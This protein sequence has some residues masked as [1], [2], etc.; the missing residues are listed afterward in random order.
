MDLKTWS[1]FFYLVKD[2]LLIGS[3][4]KNFSERVLHFF[5]VE[6]PR[7]ES[8]R[9][10][11]RCQLHRFVVDNANAVFVVVDVRR[12][13]AAKNRD[14]LGIVGPEITPSQNGTKVKTTCC[15]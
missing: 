4:V 10:F 15:T 7:E 3:D 9:G 8:S 1:C 2:L 14:F 13:N 6:A 12:P 11:W 5:L